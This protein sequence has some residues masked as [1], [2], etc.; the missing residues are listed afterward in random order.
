MWTPMG[1]PAVALVVCSPV[2][3]MPHTCM[4]HSTRTNESCRR[5]PMG[6]PT[7]ELAEKKSKTNCVGH[8]IQKNLF[9]SVFLSLS[10]ALPPFF[11]FLFL[12]LCL[13]FFLSPIHRLVKS[14]SISLSLLLLPHPL[15]CFLCH[16]R[17]HYLWWSCLAHARWH[18]AT[19]HV[20]KHISCPHVCVVCGSSCVSVCECV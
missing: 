16:T 15:F 17:T 12:F 20:P 9:Q 13:V 8:V 19:E 10:L 5:T 1:L 18:P 4:S 2:I 7:I 11:L 6:L 3:R 14:F